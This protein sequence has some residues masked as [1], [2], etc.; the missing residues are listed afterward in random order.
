[1]GVRVVFCGS[2]RERCRGLT[3]TGELWV[4]GIEGKTVSELLERLDIPSGLVALA[5]VNGRQRGKEEVLRKGD[6]L[7][8]LP[9]VGG[10]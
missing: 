2:L 5:V 9:L 3:E 7:K 8:L 1:M 10:G 4:E 6:T